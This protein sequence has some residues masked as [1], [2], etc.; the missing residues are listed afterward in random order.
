M[1]TPVDFRGALQPTHIGGQSLVERGDV[2]ALEAK[3]GPLDPASH[4]KSRAIMRPY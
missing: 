4:A 3:L 2:L 1:Y